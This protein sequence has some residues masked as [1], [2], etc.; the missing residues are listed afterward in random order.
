MDKDLL[1]QWKVIIGSRKVKEKSMY[2]PVRILSKLQLGVSSYGSVL[3]NTMPCGAG[4]QEWVSEGAG[5]AL[6]PEGARASPAPSLTPRPQ[7]RR[8]PSWIIP[9]I[10]D[11]RHWLLCREA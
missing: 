4:G 3:L 11:G 5:E 10:Q 6:S 8:R 9:K 2:I 7:P 1:K